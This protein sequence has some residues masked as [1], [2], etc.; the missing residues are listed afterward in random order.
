MA[1]CLHCGG[2]V[3]ENYVRVFAPEDEPGPYACS[4]CEDTVRDRAEIREF[5]R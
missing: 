4:H 5:Q 3:A 2:F 1:K